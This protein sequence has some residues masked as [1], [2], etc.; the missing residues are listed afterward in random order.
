MCAES[1]L[2]GKGMCSICCVSQHSTDLLNLYIPHCRFLIQTAINNAD[3]GDI[4]RVQIHNWQLISGLL[5]ANKSL[6]LVGGYSDCNDTTADP[7]QPTILDMGDQET[8]VTVSSAI[9]G[10]QNV[11]LRN[12]LLRQ[13]NGGLNKGGGVD[14]SGAV[15]LRLDNVDVQENQASYG[16]GIHVHGGPPHPT[17]SLEGGSRIG[18]TAPDV[19]QNEASVNGANSW[20]ATGFNSP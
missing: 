2:R 16:G 6:T 9:A 14:L 8:V 5:I 10:V 1:L 15:N 19:A 11:W 18:G 4:I 3:P 12:L 17:L 13:G 20:R 7:D